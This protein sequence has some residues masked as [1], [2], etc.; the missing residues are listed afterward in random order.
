VS[1]HLQRRFPEPQLYPSDPLGAQVKLLVEWFERVWKPAAGSFEAELV[2]HAPNPDQA[3]IAKLEARLG[4]ALDLMEGLLRGEDFLLGGGMQRL[5]APRSIA[6]A[7]PL[8]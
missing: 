3:V 1:E 2:D 4:R 8:G 7:V 5:I 6:T